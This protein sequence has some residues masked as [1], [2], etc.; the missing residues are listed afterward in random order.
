[1]QTLLKT[2]EAEK[3]KYIAVL[4]VNTKPY[5]RD[6]LPCPSLNV[7]LF[8][9]DVAPQPSL[10]PHGPADPP[11]HV[12]FQTFCLNKLSLNGTHFE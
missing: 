7:T 11:E 1:M 3:N 12:S 4:P 5:L 8:P 2:T 6:L 10:K 9:G